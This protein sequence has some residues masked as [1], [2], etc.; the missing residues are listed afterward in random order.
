V[1]VVADAGDGQLRAAVRRVEAGALTGDD[2]LIR[3]GLEAGERVA[4]SGSFKL[5]DGMLV[6]VADG[7]RASARR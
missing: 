6:S 2:V 3:R 1:F 7:P 5:R 4:S